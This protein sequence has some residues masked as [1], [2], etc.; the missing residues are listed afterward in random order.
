[1]AVRFIVG[2]SGTGKT[3]YCIKA[4]V[5]A[6]LDGD[7]FKEGIVVP[8]WEVEYKDCLFRYDAITGE[9]YHDQ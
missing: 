4:I 5:D 6:L 3:S 9:I 2:R 1:M 8:V 7:D